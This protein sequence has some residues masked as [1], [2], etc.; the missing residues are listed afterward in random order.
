MKIKTVKETT[1]YKKMIY[2]KKKQRKIIN[3]IIKILKPVF[4][5]SSVERVLIYG[6][7]ARMEL[8]KYDKLHHGRIYSDIDVLIIVD[9]NIKL[10]KGFKENLNLPKEIVKITKKVCYRYNS[11]F[12]LEDKFSIHIHVFNK[13]VH[14]KILALK[15]GIPVSWPVNRRKAILL[16]KKL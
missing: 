11:S 7:L 15:K 16:Y 2:S 3:K 5:N 14:D 1:E 9:G 12:N 6:S 10:P 8:G 4:K 13:N